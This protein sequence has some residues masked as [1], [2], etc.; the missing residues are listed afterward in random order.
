METTPGGSVDMIGLSGGGWT[1]AMMA[2]IDQRIELSVPVAGTAPLYAR[3]ADP[4]GCLGDAEQN[5]TIMYS[6]DI[7]PD[8]SG[9][10]IATWLEIHALGGFGDGRRQILVT[11]LYDFFFPGRFADSFK[12][13]VAE[14]VSKRL[15]HGRW[16][17]F[18]EDTHGDAGHRAHIVSPHVI[19]AI[20]LKALNERNGNYGTNLKSLRRK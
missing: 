17:Y 16:E 4:G 6:E 2:A 19:E 9:G 10:G 12:D 8:G 11:N 18:L 13:I 15:G 14:T 1:T 3:N 7:R 20:I 5:D